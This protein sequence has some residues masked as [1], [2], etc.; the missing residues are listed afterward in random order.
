[1]RTTPFVYISLNAH[2]INGEFVSCVCR[3]VIF[4]YWILDESSI[5]AT[6]T[7]GE[8]F[9]CVE[10]WLFINFICV[11]IF[12]FVSFRLEIWTKYFLE[13]RPSLDL[14]LNLG[15]KDF[16]CRCRF[17]LLAQPNRQSEM[18]LA[19]GLDLYLDLS[20]KRNNEIDMTWHGTSNRI[21]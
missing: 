12:C 1:M 8:Y 10:F 2:W 15:L 13:L 19:I 17:C 5:N 6:D 18:N 21:I 4:I 3:H 9:V 11:T 16:L 14:K 7:K 20:C